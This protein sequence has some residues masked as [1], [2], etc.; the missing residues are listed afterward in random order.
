MRTTVDLDEGVLERAK[1]AALRERRTLGSL[2]SE[3]LAAYLGSHRASARDPRFE[4]LVRGK[5]QG[6]FPTAADVAAV[7]DDE[8][9]GALAVPRTKRRAAP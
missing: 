8:E 7:E 6:R 2:L 1:Q 9:L 4:L 5:R 3:A